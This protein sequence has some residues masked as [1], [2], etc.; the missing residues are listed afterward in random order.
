[1][2]EREHTAAELRKLERV[3]NFLM[4]ESVYDSISFDDYIELDSI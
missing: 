2:E 1:M 3:R 4:A